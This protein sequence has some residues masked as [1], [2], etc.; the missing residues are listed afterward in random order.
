M[1]EDTLPSRRNMVEGLILEADGHD[2]TLESVSGFNYSCTVIAISRYVFY[3]PLSLQN[4]SVID[5]FSLL[6]CLLLL[7]DYFHY[8]CH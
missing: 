3:V 8:R 2:V 1:L 5:W 6:K 7:L 4:S